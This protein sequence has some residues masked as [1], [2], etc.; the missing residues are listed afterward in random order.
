MPSLTVSPYPTAEDVLE[1]AR[2]MSN[3][4]TMSIDGDILSDDQPY[5]FPML[6]LCFEELQKRLVRGGMNTYSKTG[7]VTGLTAV[8]SS[9]PTTQVILMYS[10]YYDG[11]NLAANPTLPDDLIVP[12]EIWERQTASISQWYKMGQVSDAITTTGQ[13]GRF[14]EWNW[15]TDQLFLPGATQSNDLKMKYLAFAPRITGPDSFVFVVGCKVALA[16][17]IGEMASAARGGSQAAAYY[18]AKADAEIALL[19]APYAR[20]EQYASF[21]R[22]PFRSR[23]RRRW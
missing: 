11:A 12:L 19:L 2:V 14:S 3:D 21:Q 5:T 20:K 15:E 16:A 9:D 1:A 22:K 18:K 8:D 7:I 23:S 6:N 4:A 17:L 10:G 13:T